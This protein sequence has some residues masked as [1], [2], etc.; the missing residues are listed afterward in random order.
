MADEKSAIQKAARQEKDR[1]K[2]EEK[3][4]LAEARELEMRRKLAGLLG[5]DGEVSPTSARLSTPN[6]A[7]P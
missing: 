6:R 2:Q 1:Q 4:K 7:T 3:A 5:G